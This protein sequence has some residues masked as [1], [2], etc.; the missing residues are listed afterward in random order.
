M[1]R[2]MRGDAKS[3]IIIIII[4]VV[5]Q[6]AAAA[7][8]GPTRSRAVVPVQGPLGRVVVQ[9]VLPG[10]DAFSRERERTRVR[11]VRFERDERLV[12]EE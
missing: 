9:K 8:G 2:A 10:R 7:V 11:R 12:V 1:V 3:I 5:F 4:I 6:N